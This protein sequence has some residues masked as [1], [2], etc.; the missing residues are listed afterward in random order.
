MRRACLMTVLG[1]AMNTTGDASAQALACLQPL[2]VSPVGSVTVDEGGTASTLEVLAIEVEGLLFDGAERLSTAVHVT[3]SANGRTAQLMSLSAYPPGWGE[4]LEREVCGEDLLDAMDALRRIGGGGDP[5]S[6]ATGVLSP[7]QNAVLP[8]W[9]RD[10]EAGLTETEK[11]ALAADFELLAAFEARLPDRA[12]GL[13]LNLR[14]QGAAVSVDPIAIQERINAILDDSSIDP[15]T[16]QARLAEAAAGPAPLPDDPTQWPPCP[17]TMDVLEIHRFGSGGA[18]YAAQSLT[19][20]ARDA[21]ERPFQ[22]AL[23]TIG[24]N[25][26]GTLRLEGWFDGSATTMRPAGETSG[27]GQETD[28]RDVVRGSEPVPLSGVFVVDLVLPGSLSLLPKLF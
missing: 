21:R 26:E 22:A 8:V 6:G 2:I 13:V 28:L 17:C 4:R 7:S 23:T 9:R 25:T 11:S 24:Q 27:L 19:W 16:M 15:A 20:E 5:M 12:G 3:W 14:P 18:P 10:R 1:L